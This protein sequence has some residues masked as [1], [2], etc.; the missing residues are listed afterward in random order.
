MTF[1][2]ELFV[3]DDF[4]MTDSPA[5]SP[6][7]HL[8]P[9]PTANN[10][11]SGVIALDN[12]FDLASHLFPLINEPP[13]NTTLNDTMTIEEFN[14]LNTWLE[15]SLLVTSSRAPGFEQDFFRQ[16]S[17]LQSSDATI[18]T[19]PIPIINTPE[20]SPVYTGSYSS[21]I[22]MP[23]SWD[24][25]YALGL[26]TSLFLQLYQEEYLPSSY[27]AQQ[28]EMISPS[29]QFDSMHSHANS[30]SI[31]EKQNM[32]NATPPIQSPHSLADHDGGRS[33]TTAVVMSSSRSANANG[34]PRYG[35]PECNQTLG[36]LQDLNRHRQTRH[37]DIKNFCC[38]CCDKTFTRKDA[39]KRHERSKKSKRQKRR[40]QHQGRLFSAHKK[41][42]P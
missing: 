20:L 34:K 1:T 14:M 24:H 41:V 15:K 28:Q 7:P 26:N 19:Q 36:R 23:S 32:Y 3:M 37:S 16:G 25:G 39:L 13:S 29:S 5:V 38:D 33:H 8:Q 42:S 11:I 10:G 18:H 31:L 40:L 4:V 17:Q 12:N 6:P 30:Y 21:S 35:C 22:H 2:N 27:E 9:L